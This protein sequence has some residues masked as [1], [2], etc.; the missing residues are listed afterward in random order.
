MAQ[1]FEPQVLAEKAALVAQK[2][3]SEVNVGG[4]FGSYAKA[5][6]GGGLADSGIE[7]HNLINASGRVAQYAHLL[8]R[9]DFRRI[10]DMGC[11]LGLTSN[12]LARR[13]Q[14][15]QVTGFE[16]S[17][18][19]VQFASR[20]FPSCR[21][22]EMAISPGLSLGG[23]YD[24]IVCQEFYPFTRTSD[25]AIHRDFVSH[26]LDHLVP[27]GILLVE[28]SEREREKSILV[29]I[30]NLGVAF[31]SHLLPYDRVF[32]NFPIFMPAILASGLL[33]IATRKPV[34]RVLL[35][36]K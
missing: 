3:P 8:R 10:A 27:G 29:T 1:W 20:Q 35:F 11:G 32:R 4:D 16:V 23:L 25:S 13:Y 12:A 21:F 24:L 15:A 14:A 2:A 36:R 5:N 6:R 17:S 31:T 34:N 9:T 26:F 19:A 18:D 7:N 28:L 30:D 22:V 33:R